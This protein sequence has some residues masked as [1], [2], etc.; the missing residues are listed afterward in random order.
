MAEVEDSDIGDT[1]PLGTAPG[2]YPD[3][4]D[5]FDQR[6]WDGVRWTARIRQVGFEEE[7]LDRQGIERG[8]WKE[9]RD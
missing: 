7:G 3:L 9:Q 6:Y 5:R 8:P 4:V 1:L 2:W